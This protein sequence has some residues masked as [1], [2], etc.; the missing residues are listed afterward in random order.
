MIIKF[1]SFLNVI[2]ASYLLLFTIYLFTIRKGGKQS[3]IILGIFFIAQSSCFMNYQL[4]SNFEFTHQH[5]QHFFF[6]PDSLLF[7]WG[8]GM[9]FFVKGFFVSS[10]KFT[11]KHLLVLLPILIHAIILFFVY[12]R[13]NGCCWSYTQ[14]LTKIYNRIRGCIRDSRFQ[15]C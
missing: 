12:H 7:F 14:W 15:R 6:I 8:P 9:L 13:F 10:L 4:W 3:N 2:A 1:I 5:L 11:R